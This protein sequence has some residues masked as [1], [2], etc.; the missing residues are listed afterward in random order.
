MRLPDTG[1]MLVIYAGA[2]F[3][4]ISGCF[5]FWSVFR[6]QRPAWWTLP[7]A[8]SLL[9]FAAL[10]TRIDLD[11]AGRAYAAYGGIYI[12]ASLAWLWAV[13]GQTPDRWDLAG[14]GLCML[15]ALVILVGRHA[16][17]Q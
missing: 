4:E 6:L 13:E 14:S 5:A 10:L 15:G 16:A 12:A 7:G 1:Q 3:F 11:L 2:A 9:L 8:L 17:T